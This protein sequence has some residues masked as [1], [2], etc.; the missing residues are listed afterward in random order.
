M[1]CVEAHLGS[2]WRQAWCARPSLMICFPWEREVGDPSVLEASDVD[3]AT[4]SWCQAP[5]PCP[6]TSQLHHKA[7]NP[8]PGQPLVV[9]GAL[10]CLSFLGMGQ[11]FAHCSWE[12]MGCWGG[13]SPSLCIAWGFIVFFLSGLAVSLR[14]TCYC[15]PTR[16][17]TPLTWGGGMLWKIHLL[18]DSSVL[19]P[20]SLP[21]S[22]PPLHSAVRGTS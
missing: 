4:S 3:G 13:R 16:W 22:P 11:L 6:L 15:L 9:V 2:S 5:P 18:D 12:I 14:C 17:H 7:T 8:I 20:D 1:F 21:G 19:L 10:F